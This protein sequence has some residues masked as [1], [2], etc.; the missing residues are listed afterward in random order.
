[1][2]AAYRAMSIQRR[3]NGFSSGGPRD[4]PIAIGP[5]RYLR[6]ISAIRRSLNSSMHYLEMYLP[7]QSLLQSL[8]AERVLITRFAI[9]RSVFSA[10]VFR[11]SHVRRLIAFGSG[12]SALLS[13]SCLA[14]T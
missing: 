9:H 4:V 1:M 7:I 13:E 12:K 8:L 3:S 14:G 10:C 5:P 11:P 2:P 6:A